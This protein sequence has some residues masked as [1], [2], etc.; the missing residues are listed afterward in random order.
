MLTQRRNTE[1]KTP[2]AKKS[3]SIDRLNSRSQQKSQ[4]ILNVI[5]H[6]H[7]SYIQSSSVCHIHTKKF[8]CLR[9]HFHWCD[10]VP[11]FKMPENDNYKTHSKLVKWHSGNCECHLNGKKRHKNGIENDQWKCALSLISHAWDTLYVLRYRW[12]IFSLSPS[13]E[14]RK[15]IT[16]IEQNY[17]LIKKLTAFSIHLLSEFCEKLNC[18]LRVWQKIWTMSCRHR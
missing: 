7:A 2:A 1:L 3:V 13:T 4:A 6:D 18:V 16:K 11:F 15:N 12:D 10:T 8:F 17:F 5:A 9:Q 14:F